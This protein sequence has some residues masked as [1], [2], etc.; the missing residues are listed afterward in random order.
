VLERRSAKGEAGAEIYC[1]P[2]DFEWNDL[3]CWSALHEHVAD[4]APENVSIANV[5]EGEDPLCISID[6]TGN[7]VH[8]PGKVIALVGVSNLVVVQ[9]KDALLITTRERSQDVG[10]VVAELKSAGRD[11]LI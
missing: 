1:L 4:C 2:G 10:K 9:T 5:F 6:S 3:G 8:A 11:D 7:Y